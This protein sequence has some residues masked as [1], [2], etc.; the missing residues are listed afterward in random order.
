MAENEAAQVRAHTSR[1]E[2][3]E[4]LAEWTLAADRSPTTGLKL[5][6]INQSIA[7]SPVVT[8]QF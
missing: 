8:A 6:R 1:R 3:V 5:V 7:V 2:R 4:T